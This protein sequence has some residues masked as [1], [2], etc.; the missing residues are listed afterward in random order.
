MDGLLT[1]GEKVELQKIRKELK[2]S[3]SD[4]GFT[5][6]LYDY[7]CFLTE[8]RNGNL[9]IIPSDIV[10]KQREDCHFEIKCNLIEEKTRTRYEGTSNGF[11]V[12][13]SYNISNRFRKTRGNKIVDTYDAITDSGYLYI[14]SKRIVIVGGKKNVTYPIKKIVDYICYKDGVLFQKENE[15]KY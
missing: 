7:I 5:K 11:N 12:R 14:T 8:V 10:L 15:A 13:L 6:R 3:D 2:L 1:E 9:P 4:I